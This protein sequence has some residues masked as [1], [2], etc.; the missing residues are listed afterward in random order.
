MLNILIGF[1][2][3]YRAYQ[4]KKTKNVKKYGMDISKKIKDMDGYINLFSK[5]YFLTG[6]ISA[7]LGVIMIVDKYIIEVPVGIA[8]LLVSLFI[9]FIITEVIIV[10]K[11][12]LKFIQ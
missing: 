11:K 1:W 6:T 5:A 7:I 4:L 10:K 12:R 8:L 9:I 3:I 2:F